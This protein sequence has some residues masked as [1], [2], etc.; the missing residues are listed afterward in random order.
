MIVDQHFRGR[1]CKRLAS[2]LAS[3]AD[4]FRRSCREAQ[5]LFERA[6]I[7]AI[8]PRCPVVVSSRAKRLR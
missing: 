1:L 5:A 8:I 2:L 6:M 7:S 4:Q 3:S